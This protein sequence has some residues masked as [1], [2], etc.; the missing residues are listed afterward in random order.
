MILVRRA[1]APLTGVAVARLKD[2]RPRH[3]VCPRNAVAAPPVFQHASEL[4][5]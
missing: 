1:T 4:Y 5:R 3:G 2:K